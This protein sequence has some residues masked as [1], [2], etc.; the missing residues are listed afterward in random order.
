M[1]L[2]NWLGG[3]RW[4]EFF[5]LSYLV[6]L[7]L[8][9]CFHLTKSKM[10]FRQRDTVTRVILLEHDADFM[11]HLWY[12]SGFSRLI[13]PYQ[14]WEWS[15]DCCVWNYQHISWSWLEQH[16]YKPWCHVYPRVTCSFH[17][18]PSAVTPCLESVPASQAGRDSTVMRR[19]LLDSMGKLANRSAAAR[20]GLTVTAWQESASVPQD[21]KWVAWA[22]SREGGEERCNLEHIDTMIY[23]T[24]LWSPVNVL[25]TNCII[26]KEENKEKKNN[27]RYK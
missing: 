27:K 7:L 8:Y 2:A 4:M 3:V 19:V 24:F 11:Q 21:S 17:P 20:M 26:N 13:K 22:P 5:R 1:T 14:A 16:L 9:W 10:S 6:D 23:M 15:L 18:H 25:K 12:Q